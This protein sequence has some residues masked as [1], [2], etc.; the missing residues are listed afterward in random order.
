M[1][2][3]RLFGLMI[4]STFMLMGCDAYLD[5]YSD[6]DK[7]ANFTNYR[8]Y[9]WMADKDQTNTIYNN[10]V[11][12]N[13]LR[14]YVNTALTSRNFRQVA[15]NPDVYVDMKVVND[16]KSTQQSP[17]VYWYPSVGYTYYYNTYYPVYY[18]YYPYYPTA[19]NM[20]YSPSYPSYPYYYPYAYNYGYG[21]S[22]YN[23]NNPDP[24]GSITLTMTDRKSNKAVWT[25]TA[26]G[27]IYDPEY[28][29]NLSSAVSQLMETYPGGTINP[30]GQ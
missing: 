3:I 25:A 13:N 9:A 30:S 16:I 26:K 19:P 11:V 18:P 27:Y 22:Y 1:K 29:D 4:I 6:Y 15:S 7:T 28:D 2:T 14:N 17:T 23:Y 10:A 5:V 24:E 8:T 21:T 12:R 20:Y